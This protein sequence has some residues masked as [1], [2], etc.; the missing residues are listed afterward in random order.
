[1]VHL[2]RFIHKNDKIQLWNIMTRTV[3]D[4][5]GVKT[6]AHRERCLFMWDCLFQV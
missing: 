6:T 2:S 3:G 4:I 5:I 1:M